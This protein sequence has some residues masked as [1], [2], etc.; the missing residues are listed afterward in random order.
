MTNIVSVSKKIKVAI[1]AIVMATTYGFA[2]V[3]PPAEPQKNDDQAK[4]ANLNLDYNGINKIDY[5]LSIDGV[6]VVINTVDYSN[7]DTVIEIDVLDN[8]ISREAESDIHKD[9][10]KHFASMQQK[11]IMTAYALPY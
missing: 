10:T 5:F 4:V 7:R 3:Q 1:I 8:T 2:T 11:H 6:Q 9:L